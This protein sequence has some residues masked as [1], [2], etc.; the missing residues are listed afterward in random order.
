MRNYKSPP[1][2]TQECQG[3]YPETWQKTN[4]ALSVAQQVKHWPLV[5][6]TVG[7]IPILGRWTAD[8]AVQHKGGGGNAVLMSHLLELDVAQVDVKDWKK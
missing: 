7:S 3:G 2:A 8:T 4:T 1:G 6:K 5:Q